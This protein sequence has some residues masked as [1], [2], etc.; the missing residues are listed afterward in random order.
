MHIRR[1]SVLPAVPPGQQRRAGTPE[2]LPYGQARRPGERPGVSGAEDQR[3]GACEQPQ[4]T[5]ASSRGGNVGQERRRWWVLRQMPLTFCGAVPLDRKP[6]PWW[7]SWA[8]A[9][10][11]ARGPAAGQGIGAKIRTFLPNNVS[12]GVGLRAPRRADW[13]LT[14]TPMAGQG[15]RPTEL[16]LCG[17]GKV[18]GIG[19]KARATPDVQGFCGLPRGGTI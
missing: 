11:P 17:G 10:W 19:L 16:A 2:G 4:H 8:P 18:S 12:I 5:A 7:A 13:G 9:E 1:T 6:T 3:L 14:L 15:T